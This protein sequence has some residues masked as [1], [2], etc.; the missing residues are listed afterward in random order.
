M[1]MKV[2]DASMHRVPAIR[3]GSSLFRFGKLI[4]GKENISKEK[5]EVRKFIVKAL[6]FAHLCFFGKKKNI[7]PNGSLEQKL[8]FFSKILYIYLH[9]S[10]L[11]I[12][13]CDPWN[14]KKTSLMLFGVC[15]SFWRVFLPQNKGTNRFQV[16]VYIYIYRSKKVVVILTLTFKIPT[17]EPM[18][19]VFVGETGTSWPSKASNFYEGDL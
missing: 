4:G 15:V 13:C 14:Q 2:W 17:L 11:Y 9:H 18:S 6:G 7:L 12:M 19:G 16:Y 3:F 1:G 5:T 8:S 10:I